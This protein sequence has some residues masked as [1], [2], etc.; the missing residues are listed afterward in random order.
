MNDLLP[1]TEATRAV[2]PTHLMQPIYQEMAD[3][4]ARDGMPRSL[5]N[6]C[7]DEATEDGTVTARFMTTLGE[8]LSISFHVSEFEWRTMQ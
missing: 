8:W 1:M 7:E 6:C 3:R 2:I 4:T 5:T